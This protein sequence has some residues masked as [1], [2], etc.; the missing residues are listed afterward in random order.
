MQIRLL[1]NV[2]SPQR[3]EY[4]DN[5]DVYDKKPTLSQHL[6]IQTKRQLLPP[7]QLY[8]FSL[9]LSCKFKWQMTLI[10]QTKVGKKKQM[11]KGYKN[12][13]QNSNPDQYAFLLEPFKSLTLCTPV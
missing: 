9:Q 6:L 3:Q 7:V 13:Q 11:K 2:F 4:D 10:Q 8:I 12:T 5:D 1:K